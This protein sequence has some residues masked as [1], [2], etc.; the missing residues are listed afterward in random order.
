[1][2]SQ[3]VFASPSE[4]LISTDSFALGEEGNLTPVIEVNKLVRTY[5]SSGSILARRKR[6]ET[7]AVDGIS[8]SVDQGEL[9]GLLGPNGA[10]KTTT[11]KVLTTLLLPTSGE[12]KVLGFDVAKQSMEVRKRIGLVLGGERGLYYRITG[13]Q[14]LRYFADLYGVPMQIRDK[15]IQEVLELVGLADRADERVEDYSR[16]MK[17]RLHLAKGIVHD[18]PIIFMDEPTI[19][20]DPQAARDTR[21]MI[22]DLKAQGKTILLTTHY[23]FEADELCDRVGVITKGRIVALDTP[24][25]LK[26]LVRDSS[27]IEVEAFG[28]TEVELSAVRS[29]P[30][31]SAVSAV[32]SEEKQTLRVQVSDPGEMLA[33]VA[34]ALQGRNIIGVRVKEPTLEDAYLWLVEGHA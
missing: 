33:K 20:L 25:G 19:G 2:R 4:R 29:L 27:L 24:S 31:V 11:I 6:K 16:G 23:M 18:P 8:F 3:A 28:I 12:V 21:K 17:Q 26:E 34:H 9:F 15:R 10:G 7:T 32:M 5:R 14:N 22:L 1:M 30:G 13:R